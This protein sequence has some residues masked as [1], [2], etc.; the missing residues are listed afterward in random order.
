[1]VFE[2]IVMGLISDGIIPSVNTDSDAS[3]RFSSHTSRKEILA[4]LLQPV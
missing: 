1:M 4:S 3:S 2:E